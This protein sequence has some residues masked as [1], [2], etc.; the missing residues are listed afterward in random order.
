MKKQVHNR[1][2]KL[3]RKQ[4]DLIDDAVLKKR[5]MN[6]AFLNRLISNLTKTRLL[7]DEGFFQDNPNAKTVE[8]PYYGNFK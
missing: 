4:K 6:K 5:P 3:L 8:T 1:A 2:G 7:L